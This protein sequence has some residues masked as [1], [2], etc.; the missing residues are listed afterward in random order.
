[1]I[2]EKLNNNPKYANNKAIVKLAKD[3]ISIDGMDKKTGFLISI[4]KEIKSEEAW[5][6]AERKE[7][8]EFLLKVMQAYFFV[9]ALKVEDRLNQKQELNQKNDRLEHLFEKI[10]KGEYFRPEEEIWLNKNIFKEGPRPKEDF[11]NHAIRIVRIILGKDTG[12]DEL[13]KETYKIISF[14]MGLVSIAASVF[15][16]SSSSLSADAPSSFREPNRGGIDFT[17]RAM[18]LKIE[19]WGVSHG[20]EAGPASGKKCPGY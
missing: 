14:S 4:I 6:D 10:K 12:Y 5:K 18:R 8:D 17:G 3:L 1:M 9:M 19:R 7:R 13:P 16:E 20:L 11:L 15:A 2:S